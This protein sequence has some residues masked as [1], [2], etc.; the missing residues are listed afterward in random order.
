MQ[1]NLITKDVIKY[2]ITNDV[3]M[4]PRNPVH[5]SASNNTMDVGWNIGGVKV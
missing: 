3:M 2:A 1:S 4:V 5:N